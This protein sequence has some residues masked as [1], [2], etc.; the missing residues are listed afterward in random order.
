MLFEVLVKL[1][2]RLN[3]RFKW[4]H[5]FKLFVWSKQ[6]IQA[7]FSLQSPVV[8]RHHKDHFNWTT[9]NNSTVSDFFLTNGKQKG[10]NIDR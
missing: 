5:C 4:L 10:K 1:Y 3:I 6:Q 9:Y 8:E 7:N 2:N